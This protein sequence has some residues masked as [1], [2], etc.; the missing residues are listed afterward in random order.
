MR[1]YDGGST[2]AGQ[3]AHWRPHQHH[4]GPERG[5]RARAMLE[6]S[7]ER[8]RVTVSGWR[9]SDQRDAGTVLAAI[10]RARF[11]RTD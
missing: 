2:L 8:G 3:I 6:V 11:E 10:Q 9:S 1:A 7:G 4:R 5:G